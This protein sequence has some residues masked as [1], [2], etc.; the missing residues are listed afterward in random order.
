MK[1]LGMK[2]QP[3][4]PS[5]ADTQSKNLSDY[6]SLEKLRKGLNQPDWWPE[7]WQQTFQFLRFIGRNKSLSTYERF[8]SESERYGNWLMN[9]QTDPFQIKKQGILK[10]VDWLVAP[11]KELIGTANQARFVLQEGL[12]QPNP[13]WRAFVAR[14]PKGLK[15]SEGYQPADHYQPSQ[16]SIAA[17][18]TAISA[19]YKFWIDEDLVTGNPVPSAKRDCRHLIKMA[20]ARPVHRLNDLQWDVLLDT[21]QRLADED[22]N[23][24]RHLFLIAALKGLFLRI[25]ELAEHDG[26]IPQMNHF[27]Q[28]EGYWWLQVYGKGRK[29]R[30]VSVPE[31]FLPFLVR[32]RQ[33]RGLGDLPAPNEQEVILAKL[34]G[35]GA[36]TS[37]HL[38]R[39]VQEV[40]DAAVAQLKAEGFKQ[41]AQELSAATTHWLRHTG[42]SMDVENDRDIKHISEDLGHASVATTDRVYVQADRRRRAES[43]RGRKI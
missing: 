10:Y 22:S 24:E 17:A 34:R 7:F 33:S 18:F 15:V 40:F 9:T 37:R 23:Y 21:A 20:Q 42:A 8:R 19:L 35:R 6:P 2:V 13:Q 41:D 12:W 26:W 27:F 3:L 32:Y 14:K 16:E 28:E 39:L 29:I 38:R 30:E 5:L 25:S 31:S 36:M 11:K 1:V 4:F 43:G